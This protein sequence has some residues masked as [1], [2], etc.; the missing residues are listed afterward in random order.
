MPGSVIELMHPAQAN[1]RHTKGIAD[2]GL[3]DSAI[4]TMGFVAPFCAAQPQFSTYITHD[5]PSYGDSKNLHSIRQLSPFR[6]D[7][8]PQNRP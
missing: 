3:S 1:L 5:Y 7:F 4:G 8:L 6:Y 2:A